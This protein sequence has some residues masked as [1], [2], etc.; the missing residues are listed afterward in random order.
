MNGTKKQNILLLILIIFYTVGLV[1]LHTGY[2]SSFLA[3]TPFQL[4]LSFVCLYLSFKDY[5]LKKHT[6]ILLI[7]LAGFLVEWIGVHTSVLFGHYTYGKNLGYQVSEVPLT[8]SLNWVLLTFT[9]TA[10]VYKWKIPLI[11]KALLAGGL[12]TFL[13]WIMEPVAARSGFWYWKDGIVPFYNYICW[14]TFSSL[15]SFWVLK[16]KTVETNKVSIGLFMILV[17]FF[18]IL[19]R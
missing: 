5:S 4:L 9:A 2:R 11:L 6:D 17:L 14:M 13:D 12:M 8:I 1:G 3:L 10:I 7:A 16:R 19:N 15:F 18:A